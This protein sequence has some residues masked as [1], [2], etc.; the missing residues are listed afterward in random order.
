MLLEG[1]F[2]MK[3]IVTGSSGFIGG[4]LTLELLNNNYDV[5]AVVRNLSKIP[6]EIL[7]HPKFRYIIKDINDLKQSDFEDDDYDVFFNLG[8]EGVS[9]QDKNSIDKQL[10]NI[11]MS[12]NAI[13][14]CKAVNCKLFLSSGTVAEYA[15]TTDVM[16][17]G[18]KQK[19]NDIYGATKVAVHYYLE[20]RARQLEQ[21]FIW[22][23]VPSTF[24]ERRTDNNIITYTI[25]TLLNGARPQYGKLEQ[26]WDFLYV[27]EVV[28][29][30]RLIAE[31]GT[32]GRIYGIGS[33]EYRP[34]REY[35]EMIRDI[36]NPQLELGIGDVPSMS[37]Q[38]FSSCV[39]IY[40]LIRDTG[41]KPQ[42]SFRE[43][44]EKT[45]KWFKD[46]NYMNI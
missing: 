15:L 36:I 22:T 6:F 21:P 30:L 17:L 9:P 26:M 31:K 2:V 42:V 13:E 24:G 37:N 20:V 25:R 27:S 34:L 46:N 41:F 45:I 33:G 7:N 5:T 3:S 38:S 12:L 29:A 19:P 40:D 44:I 32:P 43:G 1:Y 28:R 39:N 8:W 4:W 23:V 10:S 18:A 35:I 11:P 16:D 14:V